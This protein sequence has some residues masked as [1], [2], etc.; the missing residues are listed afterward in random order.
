MT[1]LDT[2]HEGYLGVTAAQREAL[3][4][5][6]RQGYFRVPREATAAE[7]ASELDVS[8]Q[9]FS[10]TIRWGIENLVYSTLTADQDIEESSQRS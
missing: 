2:S 5:A 3:V 10:E 8:Q 1:A 4:T 6:A 9:A 7:V